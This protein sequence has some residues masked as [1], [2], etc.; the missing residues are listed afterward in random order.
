MVWKRLDLPGK[1]N[2]GSVDVAR[3]EQLL[4][5]AASAVTEPLGL[6]ESQLQAWVFDYATQSRFG[7]A[8][9]GRRPAGVP[10]PTAWAATQPT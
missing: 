7:F 8:Q 10:V 1:P 2:P 6:N 9:R 4:L 5:R 3:Y